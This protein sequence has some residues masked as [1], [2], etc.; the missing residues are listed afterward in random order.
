MPILSLLIGGDAQEVGTVTAY[1]RGSAS[2]QSC[3]VPPLMLCDLT[4]S[5]GDDYDIL[6]PA[7]IGRQVKLGSSS[8]LNSL[9]PGNFGILD[10]PSGSQAAQD[11]AAAM[12]STDPSGCYGQGIDT[13]P[14][15]RA[16]AI[17]DGINA[18]F[19]LP[20]PPYNFPD[21]APNVI[22]YGDDN[23]ISGEYLG[24]GNWDVST[25][26][27]D[28]HSPSTYPTDELGA[29][30]SRYQV[31]LYELGENFA[32]N[33]KKTLYPAPDIL[34]DGYTMV[35]PQNSPGVPSS[36]NGNSGGNNGN[37]NNNN[38]NTHDPDYD[39]VPEQ[40]PAVSDPRRRI[41]EAVI[42][43]CEADN[44]QGNGGPYP[45]DGRYVELFVTKAVGQ[46]N[47][48]YGEIV[49][50]ITWQNSPKIKANVGLDE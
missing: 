29:N 43:N 35:E 28:K 4:E 30:P 37:G 31:Y 34:P 45:S 5:F 24:S 18:R 12:A 14:G 11:I 44:V 19:D 26:W 1:A 10:T 2:P 23:N 25:Y 39:G 27:S 8:G 49:R 36:G 16:D 50:R 7:N 32:V 41:V 3:S 6:D 42:L 15:A 47:T 38:N 48:I 20:A 9:A 22:N 13:A 40:N 46:D 33:G 21:P 17:R